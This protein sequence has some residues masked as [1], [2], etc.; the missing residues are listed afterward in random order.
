MAL[1]SAAH[2]TDRLRR[3]IE[4][5]RFMLNARLP[6]ERD[7]CLELGVSRTTTRKV[8]DQLER[9]GRIWRRAG[10]G[11]FVGADPGEDGR[12]PV[13][14]HAVVSPH[15]IL[16]AR[17]L[18]EPVI[19]AEA[20]VKAGPDDIARIKLCARRR[21]AA[22]DPESYEQWDHALHLAIAKATSNPVLV[23]T[24]ELFNDLRRQPEWKAYRRATFDPGRRAQ[25][26]QQHRKIAVAIA[27]RDPRAAYEA[28]QEHI[29]T[30]H[31]NATDIPSFGQVGPNRTRAERRKAASE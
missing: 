16:N 18:I 27:A 10:S 4:T 24:L 1:G 8:L 14:A 29:V 15:S 26:A 20:A 21:E 17:L 30:I 7:L 3:D 5:G 31:T 12:V 6:S 2:A 9:E 25:S 13:A 23:T 22:A 11:T 19:A 28:M